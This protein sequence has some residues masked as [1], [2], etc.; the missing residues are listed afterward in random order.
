MLCAVTL[1]S[2]LTVISFIFVSPRSLYILLP[3]TE[4]VYLFLSQ[5]DAVAAYFGLRYLLK[6]FF[7]SFQRQ[8]VRISRKLSYIVSRQIRSRL[9]VE[10]AFALCRLHTS[11]LFKKCYEVFVVSLILSVQFHGVVI[12]LCSYQE[13]PCS[14][15]SFSKDSNGLCS[16]DSQ[17]V[18]AKGE[19]Y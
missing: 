17:R 2:D 6:A 19:Y 16:R 4:F 10:R 3:H 1:L 11:F 5:Q 8:F 14:P 12:V 15:R 9:N 7:H 18:A 13:A